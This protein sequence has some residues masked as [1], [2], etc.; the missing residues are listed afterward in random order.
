MKVVL[1]ASALLAMVNREP[2][3]EMVHGALAGASMSAVNYSEVIAKLVDRGQDADE[4]IAALDALPITVRPVDVVQARRAGR[5]R[6]QTRERGLS[7]GDRAC[8]ALAIELERPAF[9]ADRGWSGLDVGVEIIMVR[10][11][12]N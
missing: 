9:T 8:L 7:L 5:L 12:G 1:D 3:A 6:G 2:G 11:P 10:R 4:V